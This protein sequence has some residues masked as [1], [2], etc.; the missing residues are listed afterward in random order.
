MVTPASSVTAYLCELATPAAWSTFYSLGRLVAELN[1]ADM[2]LRPGFEATIRLSAATGEW[3]LCEVDYVDLGE[4]TPA[5]AASQF[6]R[7]TG[8]ALR[9]VLAGYAGVAQ[10]ELDPRHAGFT[11]GLLA[12]LLPAP[13]PEVL[14]PAASLFDLGAVLQACGATLQ[15]TA[16]G[17]QLALAPPTAALATDEELLLASV[18]VFVAELDLTAWLQHVAACYPASEVAQL[19]GRLARGELYAA[20]GGVVPQLVARLRA[21]RQLAE[22]LRDYGEWSLLQQLFGVVYATA[23]QLPQLRAGNAAFRFLRQAL[24][25]VPAAGRPQ[26]QAVLLAV[27][28]G[29]AALARLADTPGHAASSIGFA[30][31]AQLTGQ[32]LL[33]WLEPAFAEAWL[34]HTATQETGCSWWPGNEQ[35]VAPALTWTFA[36]YAGSVSLTTRLFC[37]AGEHWLQRGQATN[38]LWTAAWQARNLLRLALRQ[39]YTFSQQVP[40]ADLTTS[41][42]LMLRDTVIHLCQANALLINMASWHLAA[43]AH[44]PRWVWQPGEPTPLE[45]TRAGL[46]QH[47]LAV[48]NAI[49]DHGF[50]PETRRCLRELALII[51]L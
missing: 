9:A 14:Q 37:Q 34:L 35:P 23:E 6:A 20:W 17:A 36:G 39:C 8:D 5:R 30:Q 3:M 7:F 44:P 33:P 50:G 16:A 18:V 49:K 1:S 47:Y 13:V 24:D 51:D 46:P 21:R 43:T 38:Q 42:A 26:R 10:R 25:Q 12:E 29:L 28:D 40:A 45:A 41:Q 48:I 4:F 31:L 27:R 22:C 15:P 2:L 32:L 19:L 11:A